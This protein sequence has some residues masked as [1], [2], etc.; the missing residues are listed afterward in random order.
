MSPGV[1]LADS[2]PDVRLSTEKEARRGLARKYIRNALPVLPLTLLL[3]FIP[4]LAKEI[5]VNKARN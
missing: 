4:W 1:H 5:I 3:V 2:V